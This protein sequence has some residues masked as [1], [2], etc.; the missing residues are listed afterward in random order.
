MRYKITHEL[1][2][3]IRFKLENGGLGFDFSPLKKK[4]L[5]LK[6]DIHVKYGS[7]S[8]SLLVQHRGG[9]ELKEKVQ[10]IIRDH[11][12]TKR[13]VVSNSSEADPALKPTKMDLL[14]NGGLLLA[15]P[16]LPWRLSN[17]L[18]MGSVIPK[19]RTGVRTLGQSKVNSDVAD[20]VALGAAMGTG[21]NALAGKLS[22][23]MLLRDFAKN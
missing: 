15:S 1:P 16:Y 23:A 10:D 9:E 5:A 14:V 7:G 11:M 6:N 17:I 12:P 18:V 22:Y 3:R 19:L 2:Q 20:A 8:R 13:P 4:L 21:G